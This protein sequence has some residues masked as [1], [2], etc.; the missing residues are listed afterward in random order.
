MNISPSKFALE[1]EYCNIPENEFIVMYC[2]SEC[3]HQKKTVAGLCSMR[4]TLY[5]KPFDSFTTQF[6]AHQLI[7]MREIES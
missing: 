2:H 1:Y 7:G 6:L 5:C 3:P 4:Y